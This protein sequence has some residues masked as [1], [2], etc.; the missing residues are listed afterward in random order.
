MHR[1]TQS[2]A[3]LSVPKATTILLTVGLILTSCRGIESIVKQQSQQQQAQQQQQQRSDDIQQQNSNNQNAFNNH[4]QSAAPVS[5]SGAQPSAVSASGSQ[6]IGGQQ[7]AQAGARPSSSASMD[8]MSSYSPSASNANQKPSSSY[9]ESMAAAA[10]NP[11]QSYQAAFQSVNSALANSGIFGQN[12]YPSQQAQ[13]GQQQG[14]QQGANGAQS[15]L[16]PV[17][18]FYYPAKD[19][20]QGGNPSSAP[21]S[22]SASAGPNK[23]QDMVA[24]SANNQYQAIASYPS[25]SDQFNSYASPG[26][27]SPDAAA[28]S[29]D[30]SYLPHPM[31]QQQAGQLYNQAGQQS[32]APMGNGNNQQQQQQSQSQ[33]QQG[34]QYG[35]SDLSAY[36][37]NQMQSAPSSIS[38][39]G[40]SSGGQ[41]ANQMPSQMGQGGDYLNS[42]MGGHQ[43]QAGASSAPG[44]NSYQ[45][46][47]FNQLASGGDLSTSN[48]G[49]N[50]GGLS[51]IASYMAPNSQPSNNQQQPGQQQDLF[52]SGLINGQFNS[53]AS[54]LAPASIA[55]PSAQQP[56]Q[57]APSSSLFPS[58]SSLF[59]SGASQAQTQQQHGGL[60]GANSYLSP[61]LTPQQ[62]QQMTG[63]Q[64]SAMASE[65]SGAANSLQQQQPLSSP[66]TT[67]SQ[68][69]SSSKRSLSSWIMPVLALAGL[70]L[71]IPTMNSFGPAVGRKKRSI[72]EERESASN[73]QQQIQFDSMNG[74]HQIFKENAIGE[75]LDR[76]ERYYSI[77][78]NAVENDQ[79][80]NKLICEFGDAVRGVTGK[81]V[82]LSALEKAAPA[83]MAGQMHV[84]KEAAMNTGPSGKEKCKKY[85]C[86]GA[87]QQK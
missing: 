79:C 19:N 51:S 30:P 7:S 17:H 32:Q 18:Y 52:S 47:L 27:A 73:R 37:S 21:N 80:M 46:S 68:V 75:Y 40:P 14:Q 55:P 15:N 33:Q 2:K 87:R 56:S 45:N 60:F 77:Y 35:G 44:Q 82:V 34:Q 29:Q 10:S 67:I 85:V 4:Q 76:I 50:A 72:A 86:H 69:A 59:G 62:Y 38:F 66:A 78:K 22:A 42:H 63:Q 3:G 39:N 65:Q 26:L 28:S 74:A 70:S 57:H 6:Q 11:E 8:S 36:G 49:N 81:G 31:D 13:Q 53:A 54:Q 5:G 58:T 61:F 1:R 20:S 24:S 64:L 84:F 41:Q 48:F 25:Y 16:N 23:Q 83:W 9:M 71:L 43:Q 12:S